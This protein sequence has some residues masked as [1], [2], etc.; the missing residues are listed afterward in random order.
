MQRSLKNKRVVVTAERP[1]VDR[2]QTAGEFRIGG[3][4]ADNLP[5]AGRVVTDLAL[6]DSAV[7]QAAPGNF[8]GERGSVFVINGQSG[9]SNSFLVDGLDNN[10]Q[11]SGTSLNA[12]FSGPVG[13]PAI[14]WQSVRRY[15]AGEPP[16]SPEARRHQADL[17]E[18]R[19]SRLPCGTS[20]GG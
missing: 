11:T 14:P 8:F 2:R 17:C 5:L 16:P 1:M 10:D 6:L 4:Q 20:S 3:Q 15:P 13:T 18:G 9:R 19:D 7:R 12:F